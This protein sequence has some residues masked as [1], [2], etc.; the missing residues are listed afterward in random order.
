MIQLNDATVRDLIADLRQSDEQTGGHPILSP[1][2]VSTA[3]TYLEQL[4]LDTG[5]RFGQHIATLEKLYR[6]RFVAPLPRSWRLGVDV[7][8][9]QP[10]AEFLHS[11]VL[12]EALAL[13]VAEGG[14][15][16]LAVDELASL[17]LNP[18]ALWDLN[19]LI[20]TLLPDYWLGRMEKVGA[21]L[22]SE[23]G[24]DLFEGFETVVRSGPEPTS[25]AGNDPT[26]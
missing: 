1:D 6:A 13:A 3:R 24:I 25:G 10:A 15:D 11:A 4:L 20:N 12:P 17:L 9:P 5:D 14:V 2:Q 7:P 8:A 21:Q 19:D 26:D 22:A 18:Y 23:S 16:R